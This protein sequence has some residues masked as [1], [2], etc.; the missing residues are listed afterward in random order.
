MNLTKIKTQHIYIAFI[1]FMLLLFAFS[2]S[3]YKTH[4]RAMESSLK[5]R[6]QISHV[7]C[8]GNKENQNYFVFRNGEGNHVVNVGKQICATLSVGD[9]VEVLYDENSGLYFPMSID[10]SDDKWGM[11][12]SLGFMLIAVFYLIFPQ[13]RTRKK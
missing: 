1:F 2:Y 9:F 10:T 4:V 12:G 6:V 3:R 13:T 11:F 8:R 7:E 5:R